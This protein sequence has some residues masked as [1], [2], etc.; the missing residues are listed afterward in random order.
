MRRKVFMLYNFHAISS[1]SLSS[2]IVD[3]GSNPLEDCKVYGKG[4]Q[5]VGFPCL[6]S[7]SELC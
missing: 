6:F 5:K 3:Q 1:S 4:V 7:S 2:R